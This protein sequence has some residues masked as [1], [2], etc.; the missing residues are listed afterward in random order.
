MLNILKNITT[1][2]RNENKVITTQLG[3]LFHTT[4]VLDKDKRG[5]SKWELWNK[6]IF[7]PQKPD[8]ERRPAVS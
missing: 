1:V 4:S 7:E 8:E 5:P 3:A 2:L 6:H